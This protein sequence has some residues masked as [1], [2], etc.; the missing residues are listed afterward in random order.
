VLLWVFA[1][2]VSMNCIVAL[3]QMAG[4]NPFDLFPAGLGY[5]DAYVKYNGQFLGTVGNADF[6]A[7]VLSLSIPLFWLGF[8][9][10]KHPV[11]WLILLPLLLSVTALV[12]SSVV[13]GILG[14]GAGILLTVP[15][16]FSQKRSRRIALCTVAALIF[17]AF[18]AVYVWGGSL[19]GTLYE[20]SE[21][22]HGR[23]QDAFGSGRIYIWKNVLRLVPERPLLGGGPDT[24][25]L[26]GE[27]LFSR[28]NEV[29][30]K[31]WT[32]MA[33][34][35]HNEYLNILVNQGLLSL[36]AYLTA[37]GT[38]AVRW[39]RKAPHSPQILILGGGVL[40]YCVQAFFGISTPASAAFFWLALGLLERE[41]QEM[42]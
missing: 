22:L 35:A 27:I 9:K 19:G 20:A 11:R 13:G 24:L 23:G 10:G 42:N 39:A 15:M 8:W 4:K 21:L 16:L 1:A 26:R 17:A 29:L 28:Y 18:G 34:A 14:A 41:V 33:D 6:F 40:G 7:A 30:G 12:L 2:A 38:M 37:L 25:G 36:V 32:T 31:T 3:L 5:H